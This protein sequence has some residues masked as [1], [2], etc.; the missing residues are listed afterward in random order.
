MDPHGGLF[1]FWNWCGVVGGAAL[2]E[3]SECTRHRYN[4]IE[5]NRL[6]KCFKTI[7]LLSITAQQFLTLRKPMH[8]CAFFVLVFLLDGFCLYASPAG[9]SVFAKYEDFMFT[10]L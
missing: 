4:D 8:L 9:D 5:I 1:E 6:P 7:D 10:L 2:Q 3:G